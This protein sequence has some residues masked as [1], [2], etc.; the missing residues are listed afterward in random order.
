MTISIHLMK[1]DTFSIRRTQ[2]DRTTNSSSMQNYS[3]AMHT[4]HFRLAQCAQCTQCTRHTLMFACKS[5]V[6]ENAFEYALNF[7]FTIQDRS[8]VH[9]QFCTLMAL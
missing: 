5:I 6:C 1:L 3:T 2:T 7:A 4:G 9:L 8:F